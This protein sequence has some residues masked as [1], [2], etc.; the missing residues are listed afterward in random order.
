MSYPVSPSLRQIA[1]LA[2]AIDTGSLRRAA[3]RLGLTQPALSA[4]IAALEEQLG[5]RLLDRTPGA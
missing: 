4:Q 5:A 3:A 1:A 2:A